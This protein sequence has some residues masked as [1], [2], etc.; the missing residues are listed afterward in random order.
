[1]TE[2]TIVKKEFDPKSLVVPLIVLLVILGTIWGVINYYRGRDAAVAPSIQVTTPVD[3][4]TYESEQIT[5]QG[6][7]DDRNITIKIEGKEVAVA[8]DG[9]FSTEVPLREGEN[10]IGIIAQTKAGE[11]VEKTLTVFRKV[12][13]PATGDVPGAGVDLTQTGPESF[14]IPEATLLSAAAASWYGSRKKLK[15]ALGS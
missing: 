8:R 7:T 14:W 5:V 9:A 13:S 2:G 10:S 3:G 4:E 15:K 11:R 12:E 1:M 6:K